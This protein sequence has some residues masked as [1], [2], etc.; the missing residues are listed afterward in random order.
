MKNLNVKVFLSIVL[1]LVIGG[2]IIGVNDHHRFNHSMAIQKELTTTILLNSSIL[3]FNEIIIDGER[4]NL[5]KPYVQKR[6]AEIADSLSVEEDTKQLAVYMKNVSEMWGDGSSEEV[7]N[8]IKNDF[9][10]ELNHYAA[11]RNANLDML[12]F[13]G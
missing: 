9:S 4:E 7:K 11:K 12:L 2:T 8:F 3:S 5:P 10:K 6:I 1:G 13:K